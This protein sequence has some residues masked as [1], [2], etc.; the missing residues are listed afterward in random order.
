MTEV[1]R[2]YRTR[3]AVPAQELDAWHRRSGAFQR[4]TPSWAGANVLESQGSVAPGDWKRLKVNAVGSAGFTW[5]LI[6]RQGDSPYGFVDIQESGPFA[7]W[8]H[9]HRFLP[10]GEAASILEDEVTYAPPLGN[11]GALLMEGRLN[12]TLDRLFTFRHQRTEVDLERHFTAPIPRP[13]RIAIAG[14]SGLVGSRLVPFLQAGGH[15]AMRLVRREPVSPDE[16]YWNPATGEIDAAALEGI[17]AVI[18]L[19]GVSIA[20]GRWS[21]KRKAAIRRSRIGGTRLLAETLASLSTK[22][23]VF[24]STSA[25]GYYGN[26]GD[27]VLT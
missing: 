7:S 1:T 21:A 23:A 14:A 25:V 13:S 9:A 3:I 19:A 15:Q 6:H 24:V 11:F 20:G 17:D 12:E 22:P 2:T 4:L 26:G 27:S 10:D 5:K 18:N 16:I 8:R